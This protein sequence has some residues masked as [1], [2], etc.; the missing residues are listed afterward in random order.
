M[1]KPVVIREKETLRTKITVNI[2]GIDT[3]LFVKSNINYE[4]LTYKVTP[5]ITMQHGFG[6]DLQKALKESVEKC[7]VECIERLEA[8][9]EAAGL[10][11]QQELTFDA[12]ASA[13]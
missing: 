13:N 12:P 10:G 2:E 5:V 6:T 1:E 8:Y 3:D 7:R 11:T 9:R 4:R